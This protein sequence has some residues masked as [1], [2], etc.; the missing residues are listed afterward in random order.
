MTLQASGAISLGD[1]L[2]ELQRGNSGRGYPISL[3]DSDVLALAGKSAPPISLSDLYG[4]SSYATMS[5]VT[6]SN[7]GN[8]NSSTGPGTA[9]AYP[10][11]SVSR[12]VPGYSYK[13]IILSSTG[14]PTLA[15][16]TAA[17]CSLSQG[18]IKNATGN[19]TATVQCTITDSASPS[20]QVTVT[21]NA[22]ADWVNPSAQ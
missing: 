11:V 3:G 16:D 21:V 5:V 10:S 1:V 9:Y 8:Y 17:Q 13:W 7:N 20:R 22:R 6:A 14:S 4:K 15:N 2:A 19:F 12:G 18:Y